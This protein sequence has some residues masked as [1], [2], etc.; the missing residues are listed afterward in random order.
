VSNDVAVLDSISQDDPHSIRYGGGEN[1]YGYKEIAAFR[2]ARS[3][4]PA[5]HRRR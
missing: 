2:A 1:L 4:S 5:R 3:A